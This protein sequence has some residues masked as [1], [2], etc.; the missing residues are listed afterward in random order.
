[1]QSFQQA[2]VSNTDGPIVIWSDIVK[3]PDRNI[4]KACMSQFEDGISPKLP[5]TLQ[6]LAAI[7]KDRPVFLRS[8]LNRNLV[9][10]LGLGFV[11]TAAQVVRIAEP[12]PTGVVIRDAHKCQ[13]QT[14]ERAESEQDPTGEASP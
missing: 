6:R 4:R 2:C 5:G 7:V 13:I 1:M 11:E 12:Y 3:N 9:E 8:G 14:G 10:E